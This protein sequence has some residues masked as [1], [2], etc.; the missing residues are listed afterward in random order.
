MMAPRLRG[1]VMPSS[2]TTSGVPGVRLPLHAGE[3]VS[4][5]ARIDGSQVIVGTTHARLFAVR[6]HMQ[7]GEHHMAPSLL[8]ESRGLLARWFGG[9]SSAMRAEYAI[10]SLAVGTPDDDMCCLVL[11]IS[12]RTVQVWRVPLTAG[13]GGGAAPRLVHADTSVHRSLASQV[14]YARGQRFSA[15]EAMSMEMMDAAFVPGEDAFVVLY[16]D[17]S[18]PSMPSPARCC[19]AAPRPTSSSSRR[20]R[21]TESRAARRRSPATRPS[22]SS[23]TSSKSK[24]REAP[25]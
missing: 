23:S 20:T 12:T 17:R 2:A 10:T 25:N 13:A 11:A 24:A 9:G 4:A 7:R 1:S 22:S 16:M 6:V 3:D 19:P 18:A 8:S 15:A 21:A 5:A 14:L